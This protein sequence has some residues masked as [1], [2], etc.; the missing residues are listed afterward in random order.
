MRTRY[1]R[2]YWALALGLIGCAP[3]T[4]RDPDEDEQPPV[5]GSTSGA[6]GCPPDEIAITDFKSYSDSPSTW[7]ATCRGRTFDCSSSRRDVRC[8][9][10]IPPAHDS[11][12]Q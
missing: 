3:Y 2:I 9:E 7:T 8:T 1:R 6:I 12:D 10:E 4:Y 11:A 5:E